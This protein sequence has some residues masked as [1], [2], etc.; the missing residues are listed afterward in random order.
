[1]AGVLQVGGAAAVELVGPELSPGGDVV[2]GADVLLVVVRLVTDAGVG[3]AVVGG[4]DLDACG[5]G[6][7]ESAVA[8]G[9]AGALQV[10]VQEVDVDGVD[11]ALQ[12]LQPVALLH[13]LVYATMVL[14]H[15]GPLQRRAAAAARSAGPM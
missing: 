3:V 11:A 4:D 5:K 2:V 7:G 1:M 14:R 10:A 9:D 13:H 15:L 8:G 6:A 12:A